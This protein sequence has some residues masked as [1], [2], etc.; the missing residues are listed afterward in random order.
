M[1]RVDDGRCVLEFEPLSDGVVLTAY[2]GSGLYCLVPDSVRVSDKECPVK[3]IGRKAFLNSP[4][5]EISLPPTVETIDDWAF[6][7]SLHLRSLILRGPVADISKLK[8]GKGI[9]EGAPA[10]ERVALGCGEEEDI[11][12]LLALCAGKLPASFLIRTEDLGTKNWYESFDA[13][14]EGFLKETDDVTPDILCGEEDISYDGVGMVDGE[15]PGETP[16]YIRKKREEKAGVCLR[17]LL[18]D[19]FLSPEKKEKFRDYV[20]EHA[21]GTKDPGAW[22]AIKHELNTELD[23]VKLYCDITEPDKAARDLM[24]AD[25]GKTAP[26]VRAFLLA[27]TGGEERDFFDDLRL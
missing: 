7:K 21:L 2:S 23:Y 17:R 26:E 13:A 22:G 19:S 20:R 15:M 14:L 24:L 6:S 27:G 3:A 4:F 1:I 16:A 8:L 18:K 10:I 25:M 11:A 5:K 9:L 12:Y